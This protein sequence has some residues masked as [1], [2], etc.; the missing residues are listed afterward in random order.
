MTLRK[1]PLFG[2]INS[3]YG[4]W[5]NMPSHAAYAIAMCTA[6]AVVWD[7]C[8]TNLIEIDRKQEEVQSITLRLV[9]L[10]Q[11]WLACLLPHVMA[12]HE[13]TFIHACRRCPVAASSEQIRTG[14]L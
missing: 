5:C 13:H 12:S 6:I 3:G 8:W 4:F 10:Q 11:R 14:A 2:F 1:L 9:L 7:A